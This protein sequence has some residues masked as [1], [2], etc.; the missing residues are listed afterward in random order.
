MD[1]RA[2]GSSKSRARDSSSSRSRSSRARGNSS[3]RARVSSKSRARGR[4]RALQPAAC[5]C[6]APRTPQAPPLPP[7]IITDPGFAC[8]PP[9]SHY[10]TGSGWL[11]WRTAA[12][13]PC[14]SLCTPPATRPASLSWPSSTSQPPSIHTTPTSQPLPLQLPTTL[15]TQPQ[16][17][18]MLDHD[19]QRQQQPPQHAT[20]SLGPSLSQRRES[21]PGQPQDVGHGEVKA[22]QGMSGPLC[23]PTPT[24]A[25]SWHGQQGRGGDDGGGG[26]GGGGGEGGKTCNQLGQQGVAAAAADTAPPSATLNTRGQAGGSLEGPAAPATTLPLGPGDAAVAMATRSLPKGHTASKQQPSMDPHALLLTTPPP[27]V[28]FPAARQRQNCAT[29]TS[30][31]LSGDQL[32][33][34]DEGLGGGSGDTQRWSAGV[35][36]LSQS[37]QGRAAWPSQAN[38]RTLILPAATPRDYNVGSVGSSAAAAHLNA[39]DRAGDDWQLTAPEFGWMPAAGCEVTP[40]R[41]TPGGPNALFAFT[42]TTQHDH[43]PGLAQALRMLASPGPQSFRP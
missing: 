25:L 17:P 24:T 39:G 23:G 9:A 18:Q 3:S 2:K 19:Q 35:S 41:G 38:D 10:Q 11:L 32:G 15:P 20:S 43:S 30:A 7:A 40:G 22:G 16:Q 26:G 12:K 21:Q 14:P 4:S 27:T 37:G 6:P 36:A 1:S 5:S 8:P 28:S 31:A 33:A 29:G 34:Y 42:P 13:P